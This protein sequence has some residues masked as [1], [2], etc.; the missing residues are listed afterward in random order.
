MGRKMK[1][2]PDFSDTLII[3]FSKED[4]C[5]IAHSLRT[6]QIGTGERIVD[7][8][9]D[10][11]KAVHAVCKAAAEDET[12]AYLREAP[13]D[14][15]TRAKNATQL[16][17]EIYEIAHKKATGEWPEEVNV[18]IEPSRGRAKAFAIRMDEVTC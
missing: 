10:A 4:E 15:Q 1:K 6:D 3:Y 13:E 5:W 17:I 9:T 8:L 18:E 12:I 11:I 2:I 14:V 7:A 16:P